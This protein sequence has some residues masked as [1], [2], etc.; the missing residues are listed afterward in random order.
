MG[1]ADRRT[2]CQR[3]AARHQG[4][5]EGPARKPVLGRPGARGS[6]TGEAGREA[7]PQASLR[8]GEA[9]RTV[10]GPTTLSTTAESGPRSDG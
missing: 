9:G 3:R 5:A 10:R 6:R 8:R 4:G 2:Q 1:V 7:A